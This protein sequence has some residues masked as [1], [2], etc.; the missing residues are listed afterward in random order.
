MNW[1]LAIVF[2]I[3]VLAM[4]LWVI[5]ELV[6]GYWRRSKAPESVF[7]DK[8]KDIWILDPNPGGWR[9]LSYNA[10]DL[11]DWEHYWQNYY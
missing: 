2:M 5:W 6:K 10:Q 3:V 1:T 4:G 11:E 8:N 9:K 7:I